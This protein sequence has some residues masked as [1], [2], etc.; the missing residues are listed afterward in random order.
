MNKQRE[1]RKMMRKYK[2]AIRK[3]A[4]EC[5][6]WDYS[7]GLDGFIIF[8]NWMRDYYKLGVNVMALDEPISEAEREN[9]ITRLQGL[10]MALQ[11]YDKWQTADDQYFAYVTEDEVEKYIKQGWYNSGRTCTDEN[12]FCLRK[13]ESFSQTAKEFNE[14]YNKAKNDFFAWVGQHITEWWD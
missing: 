2:K 8:L 5:A 10:N 11:L 14:Y 13:Y 9:Y 3:S 6:P 1:Y 12:I 4:R 7:F